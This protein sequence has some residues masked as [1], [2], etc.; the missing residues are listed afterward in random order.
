[1][2]AASYFRP[3]NLEHALKIRAD[4]KV[5]VAAGCTDLF[6]ATERKTLPGAV[7]DVSGISTLRGIKL[8]ETGLHIGA[9]ASWSDIRTAT[10]PPAC[11]ALQQAAGQV[12]ARQ[13]QNRGTIGGN[14]CNASPAADGVPPLLCL[15]AEVELQSL[16][17]RRRMPLYE[18]LKG[19][20]QTALDETELL[21]GIHVPQAALSGRSAFEKLGARSYLVISIVMVAVKLEIKASVIKQA[22]ISVGSCGPVATRLTTLEQTLIGQK[23]DVNLV[24][25]DLV[26]RAISPIADIRADVT[27]R[28][29]SATHL[30]RCAMGTIIQEG[31]A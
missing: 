16:N 24:T 21:T 11:R 28:R 30:I 7:L 4:R 26:C 5:R 13:I 9:N 31:A 27:Y 2:P 1:M 17:G 8:D 6:P 19:V 23:A 18:F 3:S 22:A 15:E 10:L 25:S 20:R 14:L 12:G 29:E